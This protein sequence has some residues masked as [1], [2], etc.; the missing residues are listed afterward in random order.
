MN[1]WASHS[2]L[3]TTLL[4]PSPSARTFSEI[5][6]QGPC[7]DARNPSYP[8]WGLSIYVRQRQGTPLALACAMI[9]AA[10]GPDLQKTCSS[11]QDGYRLINASITHK[12]SLNDEDLLYLRTMRR[13]NPVYLFPRGRKGEDVQKLSPMQPW[14]CLVPFEEEKVEC[15]VESS[16]MTCQS[17]KKTKQWIHSLNATL[18]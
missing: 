17:N 12:H 9:V 14:R 5:L 16:V 6:R 2:I 1:I 11:S 15:P 7:M 3:E 10:T 13:L 8:Q 18:L 4:A